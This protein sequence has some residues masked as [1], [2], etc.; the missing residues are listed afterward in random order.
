M[1]A[2]GKSRKINTNVDKMKVKKKK[3]IEEKHVSD[4]SGEFFVL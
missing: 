4:R 3:S 2:R 1:I